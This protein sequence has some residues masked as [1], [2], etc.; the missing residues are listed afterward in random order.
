MV[1]ERSPGGRLQQFAS[2]MPTSS[3]VSS[4]LYRPPPFQ[5]DCRARMN[6]KIVATSK[7]QGRL[8]PPIKSGAQ[9]M[10][11]K[12]IL[13]AGLLLA[14]AAVPGRVAA[15]PFVNLDFEQA[16]V[17]AGTP[18][19]QSF[20]A[21]AAFPGWTPRIGSVIQTTVYY[22]E[23]GIGEPALVIYDNESVAGLGF[24]PL[25]QGQRGAILI[26]DPSSDIGGSLSQFGDVPSDARSL[27]LLAD[28]FRARPK[29]TLGGQDVPLTLLSVSGAFGDIGLY[30]GDVTAMAGETLELRLGS[31]G[32]VSPIDGL[33]FS[34]QPV[35]EPACM[36]LIASSGVW[37][38]RIHRQS[39]CRVPSI[40]K[41]Q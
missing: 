2:E 33:A 29:V 25:M 10:R 24:V 39:P 4:H 20:I 38:I 14:A 37:L 40:G 11:L 22:D 15:A 7:R 6:R 18:P 34:P 19:S 28:T 26:R 32:A 31:S 35:P 5:T 36:L 16:V 3:R 27:R 23:A 41:T 30:A 17:P 9:R 1:V 21:G 13:I 12:A 8:G